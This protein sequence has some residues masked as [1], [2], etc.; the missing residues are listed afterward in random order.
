M[1]AKILGLADGDED[2]VLV[3]LVD[4]FLALKGEGNPPF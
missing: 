4:E 1:V 3:R 2:E